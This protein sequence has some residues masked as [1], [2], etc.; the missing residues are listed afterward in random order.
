[1]VVDEYGQISGLIAMEDILRSLSE[2]SRMSTMRKKT[3][4][5]RMMTRHL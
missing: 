3:T 5:E 2:I 1:M 4:S